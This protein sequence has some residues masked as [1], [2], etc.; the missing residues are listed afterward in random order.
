MNTWVQGYLDIYFS[1][2]DWR[3]YGDA[4]NDVFGTKTVS[5]DPQSV[6]SLQHSEQAVQFY[7]PCQ[8]RF[9]VSAADSFLFWCFY[10]FLKVI[11]KFSGAAE[12]NERQI[13]LENR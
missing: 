2:E 12:I 5:S 9:S 6:L 7:M 4:A 10:H 1:F 11:T 3:N 13:H 8:G